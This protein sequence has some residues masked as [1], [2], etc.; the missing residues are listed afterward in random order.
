MDRTTC[1]I[2]KKHDDDRFARIGGPGCVRS[3]SRPCLF[4]TGIGFVRAAAYLGAEAGGGAL[5]DGGSQ[6]IAR[7]DVHEAELLDDELALRALP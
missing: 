3:R 4:F 6:E 1:S 7:R 2:I 5:L